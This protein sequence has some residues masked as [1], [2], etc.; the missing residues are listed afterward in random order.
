MGCY[1]TN[2]FGTYPLSSI[3]VDSIQPTEQSSIL[4]P[5]QADRECSLIWKGG[6]NLIYRTHSNFHTFPVE[7]KIWGLVM[8]IVGNPRMI[9]LRSS[10]PHRGS[11]RTNFLVFMNIHQTEW[12]NQ[13]S[14][15][16]N[17]TLQNWRLIWI[18][19]NSIFTFNRTSE[20]RTGD[21]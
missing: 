2:I 9:T 15:Y 21:S 14:I 20:L 5:M 8:P 11:I 19:N 6:A 7:F 10:L 1:K 12:S 3:I 13:I 17:G 4:S 16:G 18:I